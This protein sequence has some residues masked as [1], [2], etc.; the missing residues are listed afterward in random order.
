M[1][2]KDLDLL[3]KI[4]KTDEVDLIVYLNDK[5]V[6]YGYQTKFDKD[7]YV[8]ATRPDSDKYCLVSHCDIVGKIPPK[9][10]Y[11]KEGVLSTNGEG[12][13]GADDRA[14]VFAIL[15]LLE[16]GLRPSILF[17]RGEETGGIGVSNF[18]NNHY[19]FDNINF[20]IEIDRQGSN[21]FV[22]YSSTV[23]PELRAMIEG[24]G[25][26]ENFGSFSDVTILTE[27]TMISHVNVSCGYYHQH[28]FKEKLVLSELESVI[29]RLFNML[30]SSNTIDK[31]LIIDV[32]APYSHN[33]FYDDYRGY[34]SFVDNQG[35]SISDLLINVIY[36]LNHIDSSS[37][38]NKQLAL[39]IGDY[40]YDSVQV[41]EEN[42]QTFEDYIN[43][44]SDLCA[45]FI[46]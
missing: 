33:G 4:L 38:S 12:I 43:C 22:Y 31:Q 14:G 9:N 8:F 15:K 34:D 35:T 19:D 20:F 11:N 24:A 41:E 10:I 18:V 42:I 32:F 23:A 13:L 30:K 40:L 16:K 5:L 25:F 37:I 26:V 1:K 6:K 36:S 39:L 44:N 3:T 7:N 2:K 17:T 45:G 27:S 28:T 46:Y 21:D 29:D